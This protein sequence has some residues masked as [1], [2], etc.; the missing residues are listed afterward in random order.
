MSTLLWVLLACAIAYALKLIGYLVPAH[1][2][3][4]PMVHR[5]SMSMTVGLLASLVTVNTFASGTALVL[6]ARVVALVVAGVALALRAPYLLVVVLG[7]VA[8]AVARL[9]GAA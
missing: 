7:A 9:L 3:D 5:I 4:S 8:A 2:L 1:W 6:D